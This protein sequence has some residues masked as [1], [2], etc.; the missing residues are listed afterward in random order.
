MRDTKSEPRGAACLKIALLIALFTAGAAFGQTTQTGSISGTVHLSDGTPIPGVT[1]TAT[2]PALQGERVTHSGETGSYVLRGLPPGQYAVT[3]SMEGMATIRQQVGVNLGQAAR[4]DSALEISST[5]ET[6]TVAAERPTALNT[7]QLGTNRTR[8]EIATLPLPRTLASIAALSPGVNTSTFN[9]GQLRI[10]GAMAFDNVIL[11]DGADVTDNLYGFALNLFIEESIAESQVMTAGVSAEYGRFTGGVVNVITRSGG[12]QF[13]GSFRADLTNPDWV[14]VTEFEKSR[15]ITH[16]DAMSEI[17]SATLGGPLLR[18]RLWFF[19]AG[20]QQETSDQRSLP[21]TSISYIY[22]VE[23]PRY[24]AKLTATPFANHT[25]QGSLLDNKSTQNNMVVLT[26]R[27][28]DPRAMANWKVPSR[29]WAAFYNGVLAPQLFTEVKFSEKTF[30]FLNRGGTST[31]ITDSPFMTT[32]SAFHYNAPSGDSGDPEDRNNKDFTMSLSYFLDARSTGSHD[33]KVG[34]EDFTAT[35][36]GG[37]SP[38]ATG[39]VFYSDFVRDAAGRP[40]VDANGRYIPNFVPGISRVVQSFATRDAE[41]DVETRTFFIRDIWSLNRYLTLNLGGR[42][43]TVSGEATGE[44]KTADTER[45]TPRLAASWDIHGDGRKKLDLTF[46]QYSGKYTERQ[47]G[48][49]ASVGNPSSLT[50]VYTGPA[51]QGV[52]FA[53][54]FDIGNYNITTGSFPLQ[55]VRVDPDLQSTLVDEWTISGGTQIGSRGFAKLTFISRDW[56]DFWEDFIDTTTGIT[57]VVVTPTIRQTFNNIYFSNN[58]ESWREYRALQL[59]VDF[60]PLQRWSVTA[61]YTHELR[62]HGNFIGEGPNLPGSS[63]AYG[64]Y[65]ELFSAERHYPEG[66]MPGY[67]K[68]RLRLMNSFVQPLGGF[69]SVHAGLIYSYDSAGVY[70]LTTTLPL[71]PVQAAIRQQ[72]GYRSTPAS[73]TI[74]FG[75]LGAG[76]FEDVHQVDLALT[77]AIPVFRTL[78]P[79]IKLDV[80]NLLNADSLVSHNTTVTADPNSP[81][82]ALGLP[83]GYLQG[84]LFGRPTSVANLGNPGHIQLAREIRVAAGIRF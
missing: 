77:Y 33:L 4:A 11:V 78:E 30:S 69:G 61:A 84:A 53:P 82:D 57:E 17:F 73:Q 62:N 1:I 48:R 35:R 66:R 6:I 42:Y 28:M 72:A 8:E 49:N 36:T 71:T 37:N 68:H 23:N 81:R 2:S 55:N 76:E 67:Q 39:F 56:S 75:P 63:S 64:D 7:T 3:F 16:E 18:D 14:A 10:N 51:G 65:P 46:A 32:N 27:T 12:N 83:T 29:R 31:V 50:M 25:L 41:L 15:G 79:W 44:I 54:G 58:S 40:A 26:G 59:L 60:R 38:S 5:S 52:G 19:V 13:T 21:E 47:F 34:Y 22:A 74:Y 9:F 70:N 24:E 80:Y 45:F 43:E 20:R